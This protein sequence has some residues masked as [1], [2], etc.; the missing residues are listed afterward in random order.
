MARD[1]WDSDYD[2]YYRSAY[3]RP[4]SKVD[5]AGVS[6]ADAFKHHH[7]Y[8]VRLQGQ[9]LFYRQV[10]HGQRQVARLLGVT[11]ESELQPRTKPQLGPCYTDYPAPLATAAAIGLTAFLEFEARTSG[12]LLGDRLRDY[13]ANP[14]EAD[15]VPV[16]AA[17]YQ[18]VA[19][20]VTRWVQTRLALED[21][22]RSSALRTVEIYRLYAAAQETLQFH[23]LPEIIRAVILHGDVFPAPAMLD[24]HPF[25]GLLLDTLSACSAPYFAELKTGQGAALLDLGQR[26]VRHLCRS[27]APFLPPPRDSASP[28]DVE[29]ATT[30]GWDT[31]L[32]A[33]GDASGRF[34]QDLDPA[35]M[36]GEPRIAPLEG[37]SLPSLEEPQQAAE[38]LAQALSS[39]AN[40]SEAMPTPGES[41]QQTL[42][43]LAQTLASA[44][45]QSSPC[46]DM[47]ADL[48]EGALRGAPFQP[49]PIEGNPADGQEVSVPLGGEEPVSGEI[50]DRPVA[51]SDD[52]LASERWVRDAA[53]ITTALRRSLYPNR[54]ELPETWRLRTSGN[55]DPNRLALAEVAATVYRRYR[56][57]EQAD[58]RGRALLVIACDGSGSLN[59]AQMRMVKLLATGWLQS[60]LRSEVQ[61]LAGLYHSGQIRPG[62]SGALVQWMYHPHKTPALSRA[63][64]VR[65]V[66]A[67]P[68]TGT[69]VQS[70]ALSLHFILEESQRL[71]RGSMVYLIL[72]SDTQWN[73][74][75]QTE[76]SGR[77]EVEAYFQN[78]YPRF[79]GRLHATLVALGVE[80]ATGFEQLLD[81]VI[82]VTQA[83]LGQAA[84]VAE[85]IAVYVAHLMQERQRWIR[86]R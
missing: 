53:P 32:A 36:T 33:D 35:S 24:L 85:K 22:G 30:G 13:L 28:S 14:A 77:E 73:R 82:T 59:P 50:F 39:A 18:Q 74:S 56:I 4:R 1:Y 66:A 65:A 11:R 16:D 75:F 5:W 19:Q 67:L 80:G 72:I 64:A 41:M 42:Q 47:R 81:K 52:L 60:T 45:G 38:R 15:E 71:A 83:E 54:Q 3:R 31:T 78:A 10:R 44:G 7:D 76:K 37:P 63:E 40:G 62:V 57:V 79:A 20:T 12:T 46:E 2:D 49:G 70:D 27:L 21:L 48:L 26:W 84:A 9:R 68:D 86:R 34:G 23:S 29:P 69:G 6:S 51:L 43:E 25:T 17:S 58:R 8:H 61:I 55:L